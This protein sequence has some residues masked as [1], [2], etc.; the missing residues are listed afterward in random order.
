MTK[1]N[2]SILDISP[3]K[4][5]GNSLK[6]KL[7][8]RGGS[9]YLLTLVDIDAVHHGI[10]KNLGW[11]ADRGII[12]MDEVSIERAQEIIDDVVSSG[13]IDTLRPVEEKH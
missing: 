10:A 2:Y 6:V 8:L 11:F 12:V 3:M 5:K 7:Q 9:V 4:G 13:Y 1:Q